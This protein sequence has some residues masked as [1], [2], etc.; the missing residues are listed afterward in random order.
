MNVN[1]KVEGGFDFYAALEAKPETKDE[2][3]EDNTCLLSGLPLT[4]MAAR[5]P[6]GHN[7]NYLQLYREVRVQK[8]HNPS[9]LEDTRLRSNQFKCPYC[10][11]L[12]DKL[13]PYVEMD[14]VVSLTGVNAA[15][16]ARTLNLY[17]CQ[18]VITRGKRSGSMCGKCVSKPMDKWLCASHL[19]STSSKPSHPATRTCSATIKTGKRKGE[20]CGAKSCSDTC[21]RHS[22]KN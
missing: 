21:K 16:P 7:F 19:N 11:H 6:C 9:S 18:H 3:N 8:R 22:P 17:P 2:M 5:L 10:R 1:Y 12:Y 4:H 20:L 15:S 13:L 14:G